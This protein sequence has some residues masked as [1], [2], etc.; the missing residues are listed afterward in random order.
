MTLPVFS[1]NLLDK[2]VYMRR[3]LFICKMRWHTQLNI[4]RPGQMLIKELLCFFLFYPG[5]SPQMLH[6]ILHAINRTTQNPY[7]YA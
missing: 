6:N 3:F 5:T 2:L 4:L 1:R 7:S